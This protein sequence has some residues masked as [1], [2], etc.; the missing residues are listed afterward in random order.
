MSIFII[1]S[2]LMIE[3]HWRIPSSDYWIL[4]KAEQNKFKNFHLPLF[5]CPSCWEVRKGKQIN[6]MWSSCVSCGDLV[7]LDEFQASSLKQF[8]K[9]DFA[10]K[11]DISSR[12]HQEIIAWFRD[13]I[14][15]QCGGCKRHN[16][17]LPKWK[18]GNPDV[19][20]NVSCE[21]CGDPYEHGKD[22]LPFWALKGFGFDD[23]D[24]NSNKY[25]LKKLWE[26]Q[27]LWLQAIAKARKNDELESLQEGLEWVKRRS[28]NISWW[29]WK[30]GRRALRYIEWYLL[31]EWTAKRKQ[32]RRATRDYV[33]AVL[34]T[35]D[36]YSRTP[37]KDD[38]NV[39]QRYIYNLIHLEQW[40]LMKTGLGSTL[41]ILA[42]W[43][44][45]ESKIDIEL[46]EVFHRAGIER[47]DKDYLDLSYRLS[48]REPRY[49]W[50]IKYSNVKDN[51]WQNRY[52]RYSQRSKFYKLQ[53]IWNPTEVMNGSKTLDTWIN[54]YVS[55]ACP[56]VNVPISG[57][58]GWSFGGWSSSW[59]WGGWM[60]FWWS[61]DMFYTP[62][63]WFNPDI[64]FDLTEKWESLKI[65]DIVAE[66]VGVPQA[67]ASSC[68]YYRNVTVSAKKY[69]TIQKYRVWDWK[70][71]TWFKS[72]IIPGTDFNKTFSE[73]R[74]RVLHDD[75]N[76]REV[77]RKLVME[78]EIEDGDG[79]LERVSVEDRQS[80]LDMAKNMNESCTIEK[81][82][83]M[84]IV[85]WVTWKDI[86][87]QCLSR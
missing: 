57:G 23:G 69:V 29:R 63:D 70:T 84:Q 20:E 15:W 77:D 12:E 43:M 41:G 33:E 51:E 44:I 61:G 82:L 25:E 27:L 24:D 54:E 34:S 14:L 32:V 22:L 3:P 19:S 50:W 62:E 39:L 7:E 59:G 6:M 52:D 55:Q 1:Y 10:F 87:E 47:E 56:E 74:S 58:W 2:L 9:K 48:R 75:D 68:W 4:T 37:V 38:A 71:K 11:L 53:N 79:N 16:L 78:I 45:I 85:N 60:W 72:D 30:D 8:Q 21:W 64:P 31:W 49:S 17:N 67:A 18:D 65:W 28:R 66:L 40:A 80:W 73:L 83:L 81:P 86:S 5:A 13:N 76:Q 35:N 36:T 42:L 26:T 46:W